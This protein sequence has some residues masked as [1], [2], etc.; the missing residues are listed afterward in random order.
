LN[1]SI[2]LQLQGI[3]DLEDHMRFVSVIQMPGHSIEHLI[4][5][6]SLEYRAMENESFMSQTL[7]DRI[8][9]NRQ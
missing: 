6:E 3:C 5:D 8:M 7:P 4:S 9:E 1:G 2:T